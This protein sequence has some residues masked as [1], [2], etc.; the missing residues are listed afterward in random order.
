MIELSTEKEI[1]T[2]YRISDNR[3]LEYLLKT[4]IRPYYVTKTAISNRE[5]GRNAME[6]LLPVRTFNTQS[7]ST[8]DKTR[9]QFSP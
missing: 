3:K 4:L 5:K 2:G 8:K 6:V 7:D 1:F 9:R